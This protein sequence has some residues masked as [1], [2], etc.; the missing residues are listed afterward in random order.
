MNESKLFRLSW[1]ENIKTPEYSLLWCD[2]REI[3]KQFC[4][5]Q[6]LN[7]HL[8]P[9]VLVSLAL[10]DT[11]RISLCFLPLKRF[12]DNLLCSRFDSLKNMYLCN[13]HIT[14]VTALYIV[15]WCDKWAILF[16]NLS[17]LY[18]NTRDTSTEATFH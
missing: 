14:F 8:P 10:Q 12:S 4:K 15:I 5:T 17:R 16:W 1:Y 9:N 7:N 6:F 13:H 2:V 11:L 3:W 18:N